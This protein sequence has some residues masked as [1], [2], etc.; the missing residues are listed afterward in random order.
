V[1]GREPGDLEHALHA[2]PDALH[3]PLLGFAVDSFGE[4]G[5]ERVGRKG[6]PLTE[7]LR[8]TPRQERRK[9]HV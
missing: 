3:D 9:D 8:P 2:S 6:P 1:V 4:L 7:R 5:E